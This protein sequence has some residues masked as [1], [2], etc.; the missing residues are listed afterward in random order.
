[1][2]NLNQENTGK[3]TFEIA[4]DIEKSLT[5]WNEQK[6]APKQALEASS[7]TYA[8]NSRFGLFENGEWVTPDRFD[9]LVT[10][11]NSLYQLTGPA[12]ALYRIAPGGSVHYRVESMEDDNTIQ[13]LFLISQRKKVVLE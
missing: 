12:G 2:K 13:F 4:K 1:M 8:K 5:S 6:T 3:N 7:T 11:N 9:E 10:K